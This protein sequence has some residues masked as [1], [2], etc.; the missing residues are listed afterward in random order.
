[1]PSRDWAVSEDGM[2]LDPAGRLA[3]PGQ[4]LLD[5][6]TIAALTPPGDNPEDSI[7]GAGLAEA[8]RTTPLDP[9]APGEALRA[10][11]AQDPRFAEIDSSSTT[12]RGVLFLPVTVS[13][14]DEMTEFEGP[15]TAELVDKIV[16]RAQRAEEGA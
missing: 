4:T 16:E 10:Q 13:G 1:M 2:D 7:F 6:V 11:I 8:V 3:S 9:R 12:E 15:L 14:V 5:F